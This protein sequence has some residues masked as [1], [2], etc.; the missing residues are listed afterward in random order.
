[1]SV[2]VLVIPEDPTH[3]GYILKPMVEMVLADAG[4]PGAKVDL[5]TNPRLTGYDAAV[6]AIRNDLATRYGFMDLWLFLPDADRATEPSMQQLEEHLATQD[7]TLLCCPAKPEVEIYAC[8][9]YRNEI[10]P[11]WNEVRT[12]PQ[13]KEAIFDPLLRKH[14]DPRRP[15]G[16]RKLM[17]QH[18]I[19]NRRTSYR[20]C[21]EVAALRSRIMAAVA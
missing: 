5:L 2:R 21:P 20:L 7:V 8:V 4:K 6:R 18:S 9:G 19:A 3:N 12:H 14:G 11:S 10:E 16:G 13:M 17:T 15:G 1:M